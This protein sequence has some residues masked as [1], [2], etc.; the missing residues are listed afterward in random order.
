MRLILPGIF[1][2]GALLL[3]PELVFADNCSTP[4]D[5][6][7]TAAGGAA[8]AG[9]VGGMLTFYLTQLIKHYRRLPS[10]P[11]VWRRLPRPPELRIDVDIKID[12]HPRQ[13]Q[14]KEIS[15][16]VDTSDQMRRFLRDIG[17]S[18][19]KSR[20][21]RRSREFLEKIDRGLSSKDRNE[22]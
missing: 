20:E 18:I 3:F 9:G 12:L 17:R 14:Q 10:P 4:P 22:D 13:M 16:D 1:A 11:E 8:T 6:W 7:G 15:E 19:R 5:C 2:I 21:E